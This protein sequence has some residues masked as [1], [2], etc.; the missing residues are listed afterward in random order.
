[1]SN[2]ADHQKLIFEQVLTNV[3][4]GYNV[5][6][7]LFQAEVSG[8]YVFFADMGVMANQDVWT[9]IIK[10]GTT[11]VEMYNQTPNVPGAIESDSNMAIIHLNQGDTVWVEA[12][13][14]MNHAEAVISG[15]CS[16]SGFLLYPDQ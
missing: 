2:V 9:G 6:T 15:G 5:N 8:V 7:G 16:F 10:D 1:M 14:V 11:L 12:L 4:A 13:R 3:G